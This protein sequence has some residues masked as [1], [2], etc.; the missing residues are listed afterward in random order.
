M[1]PIKRLLLHYLPINPELRSNRQLPPSSE[2]LRRAW[3]NARNER[4]ARAYETRHLNATGKMP[5]LSP[6]RFDMQ[7]HGNATV[8]KFPRHKRQIIGSSYPHGPEAA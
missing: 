2:T 6:R 7:G 8:V 3:Q 4:R 1:N 5:K